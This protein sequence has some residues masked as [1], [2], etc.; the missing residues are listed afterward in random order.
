MKKCF[1]FV[2]AVTFLLT[3]SCSSDDN[4]S[5]SASDKIVATWKFAGEMTNGEFIPDEEETCDDEILK[6]DTDFSARLTEKNC[7][8]DDAFTDFLWEKL[9]DGYYRIYNDTGLD[10]DIE[11]EFLNNNQRMI[12][13]SD[14]DVSPDVWDKQ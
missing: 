8:F 1:I 9:G 12:I 7:D 6:M 13:Y 3:V 10:K 11:V 14:T 2:L 4:A 5:S